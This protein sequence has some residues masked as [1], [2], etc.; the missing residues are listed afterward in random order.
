MLYSNVELEV[1]LQVDGLDPSNGASLYMY[2][3]V[4]EHNEDLIQ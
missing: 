1:L 4:Y 2:F 3:H